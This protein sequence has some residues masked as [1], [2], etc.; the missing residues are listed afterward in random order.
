MLWNAKEARLCGVRISRPGC[1]RALQALAHEGVVTED[2]PRPLRELGTVTFRC[3]PRR[4]RRPCHPPAISSSHERYAAVNQGSLETTVALG[5]GSLTWG[6]GAGKNGMAY[7]TRDRS[8]RPQRMCRPLDKEDIALHTHNEGP[9]Q[10]SWQRSP[11]AIVSTALSLVG[12][13]GLYSITELTERG[14]A[15]GRELVY[16]GVDGM[17]SAVDGY[18]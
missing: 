10:P 8:D 11:S 3:E 16:E 14:L 1:R 15:E 12:E 7:C 2:G 17:I 6:G 4:S 13:I 18:F 5:S 9:L